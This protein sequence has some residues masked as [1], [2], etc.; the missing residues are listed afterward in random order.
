MM[1]TRSYY[2]N[3]GKIEN[4]NLFLFFKDLNPISLDEIKNIVIIKKKFSLNN[5]LCIILKRNY[6]LKI[7]SESEQ[8]TII[9]IKSSELKR[10]ENFRNIIL[11]EKNKS[12]FGFS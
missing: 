3:Y 8:T 6:E 9:P 12:Y 7:V 4:R 1:K 2:S 11:R 5:F 10:V